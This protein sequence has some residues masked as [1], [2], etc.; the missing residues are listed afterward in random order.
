MKSDNLQITHIVEYR[1]RTEV[2]QLPSATPVADAEPLDVAGVKRVGG[3]LAE[4]S[5]KGI[6]LWEFGNLQTGKD[7]G[8]GLADREIRQSY[9]MD[10]KARKASYRAR[11]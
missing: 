10:R 1:R 2:G 4:H 8:A 11:F 3:Q 7:S 9:T 6:G 5:A